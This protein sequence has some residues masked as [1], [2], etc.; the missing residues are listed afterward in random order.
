MIRTDPI[1]KI[2][3]GFFA[4]PEKSNTLSLLKLKQ[5]NMPAKMKK[6]K[7]PVNKRTS[8]GELP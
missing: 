5:L 1:I 4:S 2:K 3:S 6:T 8:P 7:K